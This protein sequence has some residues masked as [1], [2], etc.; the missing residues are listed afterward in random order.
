MAAFDYAA[1]LANVVQ[2]LQDH[3]TNTASPDLSSSL[4]STVITVASGDPENAGTV[5]YRQLPAV[6]VRI[7][8]GVESFASLGDTGPT[9]QTKFKEVI[10]DIFGLYKRQ[11]MHTKEDTHRTQLYNLASNIEGALQAE[12][13]LSGTALW[14]QPESTDFQA[15]QEEGQ[16]VKGVLVTL[17]ARYLFR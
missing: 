8:N 10:Y 6:L 11:G 4:S 17:R 15:F 1:K 9:G 5:Q 3:N 2:V 7:N 12:I 13:T 14:C 16:I